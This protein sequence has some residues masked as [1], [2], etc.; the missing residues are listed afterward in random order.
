MDLDPGSSSLLQLREKWVHIVEESTVFD[1][2]KKGGNIWASFFSEVVDLVSVI[3][4]MYVFSLYSHMFKPYGKNVL[5]YLRSCASWSE[6]AKLF[7][8]SPDYKFVQDFAA[9]VLLYKDLKNKNWKNQ[10]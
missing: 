6:S 3:P 7:T 2:K 4:E 8:A 1:T 5:Q 10:F 9:S